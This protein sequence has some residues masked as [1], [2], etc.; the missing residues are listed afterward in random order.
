MPKL[1]GDDLI[2]MGIK[3]GPV[4]KTVLH[5]LRNARLNGLVKTRDELV[6]QILVGSGELK[7]LQYTLDKIIELSKPKNK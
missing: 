5:S 1:T 6:Y 2:D 3:P 4:F 7:K